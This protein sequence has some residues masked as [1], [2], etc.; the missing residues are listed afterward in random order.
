LGGWS[1]APMDELWLPLACVG[2]SVGRSAQLVHAFSL[3]WPSARQVRLS[4]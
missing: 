3:A 2:I 4:I 1:L